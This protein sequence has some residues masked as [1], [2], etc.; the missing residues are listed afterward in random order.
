MQP[1][2]SASRHSV[3][4]AGQSS[5]DISGGD[6]TFCHSN[7][8]GTS[9]SPDLHVFF[10]ERSF[11]PSSLLPIYRDQ[12]EPGT[13]AE[14][15]VRFDRVTERMIRVVAAY[16]SKVIHW[17]HPHQPKPIDFRTY[18]DEQGEGVTIVINGIE[19]IWDAQSVRF[20]RKY[21]TKPNFSPL[22]EW[23]GRFVADAS[24]AIEAHQ[25]IMLSNRRCVRRNR[26]YTVP[27]GLGFNADNMTGATEL[28]C[29]THSQLG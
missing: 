4:N 14:A 16:P 2:S 23:P 26:N 7:S 19:E 6:R 22:S 9:G 13:I 1:A 28:H 12:G 10:G 11:W 8:F 27:D 21:C 18:A 20:L 24:G 3:S 25:T 29:S 17:E 5:G 15:R